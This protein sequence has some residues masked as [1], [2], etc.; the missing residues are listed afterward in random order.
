[1]RKVAA[2]FPERKVRM[3]EAF[4]SMSEAFQ[5]LFTSPVGDA[6]P[7]GGH[8]FSIFLACLVAV[9]GVV[10]PLL[11]VANIWV[12]KAVPKQLSPKL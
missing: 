9:A 1:M 7:D 11:I 12:G 2:C 3:A 4:H 6:R 10:E 5:R 8:R